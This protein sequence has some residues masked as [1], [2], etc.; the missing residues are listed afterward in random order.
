MTLLTYH[1]VENNKVQDKHFNYI[2]NTCGSDIN[3]P[4]DYYYYNYYKTI[5]D[6]LGHVVLLKTRKSIKQYPHRKID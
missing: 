5:V 6:H 3:Y 2:L 4:N 1:K